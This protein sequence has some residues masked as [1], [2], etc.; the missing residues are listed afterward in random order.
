[1]YKFLTSILAALIVCT[2]AKPSGV[3][4]LAAAPL[5]AVAYANAPLY[6]AGGSNQIDVRNNYDGTLSSYT[7]T[8]FHYSGPFSSRYASGVPAA[9]TTAAQLAAPTAFGTPWAASAFS[10]K[11][12]APAAYAA[13][14]AFAAPAPLDAGPAHLAGAPFSAP[15]APAFT[16]PAQYAWFFTVLALATL[17]FAKPSHPF[18]FHPSAPDH[19]DFAPPILPPTHFH[20]PEPAP[21]PWLPPPHLHAT[22][23][24]PEPWLPAPHLHAAPTAPLFADPAP[25]L[26]APAPLLPAPAA[27]LSTPTAVFPA[28]LLP[29]PVVHHHH[30]VV[31]ASLPVPVLPAPV[32]PPIL[33]PAPFITPTYR[34]IPGSKTTTNHVSIRY[35]FPK[36]VAPH[37][38]LHAAH[39]H[40]APLF[41]HH[42]HHH[43]LF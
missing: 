36:F 11:Y 15:Y 31:P 1:M 9:Y 42:K 19:I 12:A 4:P 26:P 20:A 37:S 35:A 13:N 7:T 23:F 38:H 30:H 6:A 39:V 34:A 21:D 28:P 40:S 41:A 24:A 32:A 27:L 43:S 10:A 22:A 18:A 25:V 17:V 8:P 14:L 16:A 5:A 2:S 33:E 29:A 3:A